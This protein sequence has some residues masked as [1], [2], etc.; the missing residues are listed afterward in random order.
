MFPYNPHPAH[1]IIPIILLLIAAVVT[2]F[3]PSWQTACAFGVILIITLA[4]GLWIAV[5][6]TI[7]KYTDY[8]REVGDDI[9]KLQNTP[10]ELWGALGF[11]APAKS[12]TLRSNVTGE[13]GESTYYTEKVFTISLSPE[14]MQIFAD[15]ILTGSK[16]LAESDWKDTEIGQS[17]VRE[18]KHEMVRAGLATLRNPKNRLDGY[19]LTQKGLAYLYQYA[20]EWVRAD[21]SLQVMASRLLPRPVGGSD[22]VQ[23]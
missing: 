22:T 16:T 11:V 19:V 17:K 6:G 23:L 4:T 7:E 13:E 1:Q 20:S 2:G 15:A 9:K 14:Q 21:A 5:S 12:V 8:W 10:P 18:I 3:F